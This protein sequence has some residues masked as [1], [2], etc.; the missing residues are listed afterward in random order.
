[1]L[2]GQRKLLFGSNFTPASIAGLQ[3]WFD[4]AL[5]TKW[6]D[7]ARTTPANAGNDPVGAIDDLSGNARHA[8]QATDA[9]RPLL[10]LAFQAGKPVIRFDGSNDSLA[11][12]N[13]TW[14]DPAHIFLVGRQVTWILNKNVIDAV[15]GVRQLYD[16]TATPRVTLYKSADGPTSTEWVVGGPLGI[17]EVLFNGASSLI[18]VN[19][20]ADQTGNA[21][22][23]ATTG[24]TFAASA[25]GAANFTNIDV[26][27]FA[28]YNRS[29]SSQERDNLRNYFN[30]RFSIY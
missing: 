21:G 18:R 15:S 5:S 9:N 17:V 23:S 12:T 14:T 27:A 6:Q 11:T 8:T 29:L 19:N 20:G 10:I 28:G 2:P 22:T 24:I 25:G 13:F 7:S 4:V 1:M 26:A 30:R 3:V 16:K